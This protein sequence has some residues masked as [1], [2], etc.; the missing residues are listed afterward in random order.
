MVLVQ[1]AWAVRRCGSDLERAVIRA[2]LLG[3]LVLLFYQ[4]TM[5]GLRQRN[6]WIMIIAHTVGHIA[7]VAHLYAA[8][9]A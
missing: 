3:F 8:L 6:L 1:G 2:M 5:Y 9:P 7:L 4:F